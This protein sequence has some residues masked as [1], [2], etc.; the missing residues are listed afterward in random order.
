MH[1]FQY[2]QSGL[3]TFFGAIS[4]RKQ[5]SF[6]PGGSSAKQKLPDSSTIIF[7]SVRRST[8]AAVLM[9]S[10]TPTSTTS[11]Y[12]N[13]K[14]NKLSALR[15]SSINSAPVDGTENEHSRMMFLKSAGDSTGRVKKRVDGN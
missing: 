4:F 10:K 9:R 3:S 8:T 1:V 5:I 2:K 14:E 6:T 7:S 12:R 15:C 13:T 11:V